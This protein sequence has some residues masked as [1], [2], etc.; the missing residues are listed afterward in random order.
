MNEPLLSTA[1][2]TKTYGGVT[3]IKDINLQF[4]PG[5]IHALAGE[6]GAG[7]ST[8][9]KAITGAVRL[10]SG[11]IRL[12]ANPI[13]FRSPA[14]A[15]AAGIAMVYQEPSLVSSMTVAQNIMLGRERLVSR[16]RTVNKETQAVMRA[17]NFFV[18][19]A[20]VVENLGSGQKQMVEIARAVF[21]KARLVIFDEPT[22]SLTVFEKKHFFRLLR[23]LKSSGASIIYISHVL[24]E[25]LKVADRISV[26]RDGQ[27]V[28]TGRASEV[29]RDRLVQQMVGRSVDDTYYASQ[30]SS[31]ERY[32]RGKRSS[33]LLTEILRVQGLR[34]GRAVHNMSFSL[35]AGEVTGIAGLIGS[36][37]TEASK[38]VSGVLKRDIVDG[39]RVYL[40]GKAVRY[41]Q[42]S[43]AVRD[44]IV[45]VTEDRKLDGFFETMDVRRNIELGWLA[46]FAKMWQPTRRKKTSEVAAEWAMRLHVRMLGDRAQ[47]VELSGGN[48]Q[49][50]VIAK[51]IV[52]MPKVVFFDEPTRG[53]DVGSIAEIHQFIRALAAEGVAVVVI[54]SY[55]PEVLSVSDRILVARQGRIVEELLG[56][57]ATPDK[58]MYAAVS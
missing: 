39:G 4:Y 13:D 6:N 23:M 43:Q 55:L 34:M 52:Q 25:S 46:R 47:L 48:Q 50:V 21:H 1:N 17:M 27:L 49:K 38:V 36:G 58:I 54:S 14:E 31:R 51:S 16:L 3:A 10:T 41:R 45:Y 15:M 12:G 8:L 44:G 11:E 22:A 56:Y 19:P 35:R 42:P 33:Q 24:E 40:N 20:A 53:V 26:L 5:E 28:S 32:L 2:A 18:D 29:T 9:C 37:R 7:K 57:E 30:S